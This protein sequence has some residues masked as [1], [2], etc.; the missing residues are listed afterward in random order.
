MNVG[1]FKQ[2]VYKNADGEEIG[3]TGGILNFPFLPQL[4][5]ALLSASEEDKKKNADFPDFQIA[6]QKPKGYE[7][8]R[9][10]IGGLWYRVSKDGTKNFISGYIES[11]LIPGYKVYIALFT[12]Q[13]K[14]S[15]ILYDVVWSAP[16]REQRQDVPPAPDIA[17]VAQYADDDVIPF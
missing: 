10:I 12:Q 5:V 9:Q 6:L 3:Y 17:D 16:R 14:S 8:K 2:M 11:P 1:Y 13:E 7:G 15:D 4:Q